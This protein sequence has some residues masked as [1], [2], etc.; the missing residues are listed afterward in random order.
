MSTTKVKILLMIGQRYSYETPRENDIRLMLKNIHR[1]YIDATAMNPFYKMNEPIKSK[2]LNKYLDTIF[3]TDNT[4][5]TP[6]NTMDQLT[7]EGTPAV[8]TV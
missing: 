7:S 5:R 4:S 3:Q 6:Q 2:S 8:Q 1:A